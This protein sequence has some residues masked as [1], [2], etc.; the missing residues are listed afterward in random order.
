MKNWTFGILM[1]LGVLASSIGMTGCLDP[2][3]KVPCAN[4]NCNEGVCTCNLGYVGTD[5]SKPANEKA[6]GQFLLHE[7]CFPSGVFYDTITLTPVPSTVDKFFYNGLWGDH[8]V[9]VLCSFGQDGLSFSFDTTQISSPPRLANCISGTFSEDGQR[10]D[11]IY[12]IALLNS[13]QWD[14]SCTSELT[15][16]R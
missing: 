13:T 4:G 6:K 11:L 3:A 15:K 7:L 16:V 8:V 10:V 9:D 1:G 2:C 14:D 5:C 12:H